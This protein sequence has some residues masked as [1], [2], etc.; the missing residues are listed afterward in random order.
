[1]KLRVTYVRNAWYICLLQSILF[2][3]NCFR[4]YT[5]GQVGMVGFPVD[6]SA[7]SKGV[8]WVNH[9][10]T[11]A[12][13]KAYAVYEVDVDANLLYLSLYQGTKYDYY[14]YF[15]WW[16]W[17]LSLG[18]MWAIIPLI[19]LLTTAKVALFIFWAYVAVTSLI[20]GVLKQRS[21]KTLAC[22]KLVS[23]VLHDH[24]VDWNEDIVSPYIGHEIIKHHRQA[25][26][27]EGG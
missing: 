23:K 15:N 22:Q 3:R 13:A 6:L 16:L 5:H 2:M 14:F 25:K 18:Y 12:I 27:V 26:F 1:M 11:L 17:V 4:E 19:G 8:F 10:S 7:E 9:K 21:K 24:G 20:G